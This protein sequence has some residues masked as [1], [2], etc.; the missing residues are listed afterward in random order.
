M[1]AIPRDV[2]RA[3]VGVTANR[4]LHDGVHR[5]WLRRRYIEALERHACVECVILPTIDGDLSREETLRKFRGVMSRLDGLVLTGDESNLD[6]DIFNLQQRAWNR[7]SDDVIPGERDRPRDRLSS[8]ALSVAIELAMP[9]LGICRGLQ[10]MSV[11]RSGSLHADLSAAGE[12]VVHSENPNVPRDQ[13]YLPVHTVQ[14]VPGGLLSSIV[15]EGD[16]YVNSLHNQGITEVASGV[17][18]EAVA[19]DGVIEA[20]SYTTSGTFQFGVQWHPEWHAAT[21]AT[22][23][24][25]F[26]AFG[27]ACHAYQSTGPLS[28]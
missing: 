14:V 8:I 9:I 20:L 10:E 13:Q 26:S 17:Q 19:E 16:L 24:K 5:D 1:T 28:G 11:H 27:N 12:G 23:Q 25:I 3:V 7:A 22:S 21:D 18:R 15:G 4:Q 2:R 6:P